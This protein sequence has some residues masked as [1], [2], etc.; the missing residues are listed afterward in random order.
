MDDTY[1]QPAIR[2]KFESEERNVLQVLVKFGEMHFYYANDETQKSITV[3]EYII[4]EL[5][6]D[7]I[8]F[9]N[10]IHALML[11]EYKTIFHMDNFSAERFF[12]HHPNNEISQLT[13]DL[14]SEKYTLSKI[15]SKVKKVVEDVD[16][17]MDLVPRVILEFKNSLIINQIKE[18]LNEMK[19]ANDNKNNKLL[20]EIM[21]QM[22]QLEI[23]KK[24]LSKT[25][26]ERIIIKL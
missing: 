18:K 17:F 25:L 13:A 24:Q 26:G 7:G 4:T 5:E 16:R 9:E 1:I 14:I 12:L 21:T 8:L 20:D 2:S 10:T 15:H 19:V 23:I 22:S 3:G 11:N 6:H